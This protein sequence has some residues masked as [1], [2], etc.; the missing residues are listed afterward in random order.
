MNRYA[1]HE[2]LMMKCDVKLLPDTPIE[3]ELE[4]VLSSYFSDSVIKD[5][6]SLGGTLS[7]NITT[8]SRKKEKGLQTNDNFV[9]FL[10]SFSGDE[11]ELRDRLE[12]LSTRQLND[13]ARQ[14][15][16][17]VRSG[18]NATELI[19]ALVSYATSSRRWTGISGTPPLSHNRGG[20]SAVAE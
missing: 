6:G 8:N 14:L 10:K 5:L 16:I 18:S 7:I 4:R 17:P 13:I 9:T 1:K 15:K 19:G 11:R 3:R 20:G 12:P 2:S